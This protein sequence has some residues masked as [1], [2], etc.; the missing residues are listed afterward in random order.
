[1]MAEAYK[2]FLVANFKTGWSYETEPWLLP[3][4]AFKR[5][6][7]AYLY[8][9]I[10]SKRQGYSKFVR[11]AHLASGEAYGTGDGADATYEHTAANV[12]LRPGGTVITGPGEN[13]ETFT[14][15]GDGTLTGDQGGTGTV[16]YDTGEISVTFNAAPTGDIV[17]DYYW[18]PDLPIVGIY[19]YYD[20]AGTIDAIIFDTKRVTKYDPINQ[21]V[22]DLTGGADIFT[23]TDVNLVWLE[24]WNDVSYF[25]NFKD[26]PMTYDGETVAPLL[27]DTNGD[28]IND[29][30]Q[31]LLVFAFKSR[32]VILRTY[33]DG[34]HFP[35]RARWAKP[36]TTDFSDDEY[37]DA[38]TVDWIIGG[39]FL[40]D[41]LI[42]YFERSVWE[43]R[44]TGDFD[45]PFDWIKLADTEG[46]Y[47]TFSITVFA[48]E[49]IALGP[50][51]PIVCDG[52][53]VAPIDKLIPDIVTTFSPTE[54]A[55]AYATTIDDLRQLW[56]SYVP[57]GG[58]ICAEAL[59]LNYLDRSWSTYGLPFQCYGPFSNQSDPTWNDIELSWEEI[60]WAWNEK[61]LQAGYP[62]ILGGGHNGWVYRC[63]YGSSD[64]GESIPLE[65]ESGKWN[66]FTEEGLT[67]RLGWIDFLVSVDSNIEATVDIFVDGDSIPAITQTLECSGTGDKAWKRLY[68]DGIIANFFLMKISHDKANQNLQIHAVCPWFRRGGRMI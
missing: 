38:P 65:I 17:C 48:N 2:P 35:Q 49:Q 52:L 33:E 60:E 53:D 58:S 14:D 27:I 40:N 45:L 10:I 19:N 16:N 57:A 62:T 3:K 59:V 25:T 55:R 22:I 18:F 46:S 9:G 68:F 24:N 1:M 30:D 39:E 32:L 67:A 26:R 51:S 54:I 43:L 47:A 31:A 42:I 66:P 4:D 13:P 12:P 11:Q 21:I 50:T 28:G 8:R 7:N 63:N 56:I 15:N 61:T 20:A 64:D 41:K 23:G 34:N 36:G 44:Y 37:V 29:V 5:L 6:Y